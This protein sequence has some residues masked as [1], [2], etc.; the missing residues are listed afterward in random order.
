VRDWSDSLE[1]LP[2]LATASRDL[3]DVQRPWALKAIAAA[4]PPGSRL[5]EIGAGEPL[6]AGMLARD[7]YDVTVVDPYDGRDGGP[8]DVEAPPGVRV[9]RG[10][11]PRDVP[12][13]ER[14]DCV[15]SIS[16]L[17][18]LPAAAIDDVCADP[19]AHARGRARSTPSTTSSSRAGADDTSCAFARHRRARRRPGR[20]RPC[21]SRRSPTRTRT[22]FRRGTRWRGAVL[23]DEFPMRRCVS[24]SSACRCRERRPDVGI[25]AYRSRELLRAC[26][27]RCASMRRRGRCGYRGRQRLAR[28]HRRAGARLSGRRARRGAPQPG[29]PRRRTSPSAGEAPYF[30]RST[31]TR[32]RAGTL[33]RLLELMDERPESA[34]G[35]R[36]EREDGGFDHAARRPSPRRSGPLAHSRARLQRPRAGALAQYRARKSSAGRSTPSAAPSC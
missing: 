3:K 7:G 15:Y 25:V 23:R 16:V 34:S 35:P 30:S 21:C 32:A 8:S 18:H 10:L 36:L 11:F 14:F 24:I 9:I 2:L 33:D 5:L 27:A 19:R 22:S 26:L 31:P 28:R 12:A 6:V 20:A 13:A 4:V 1:R 17:E 29:S